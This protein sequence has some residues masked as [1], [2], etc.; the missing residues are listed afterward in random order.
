M[1]E[2][3]DSTIVLRPDANGWYSL[4]RDL[5]EALVGQLRDVVPLER[6]SITEVPLMTVRLARRLAGLPVE[7]LWLWSPVTRPAL[8]H[9]LELPGL[10]ELDVHSLHGPGR[11]AG[12]AGTRLEAARINFYM[13]EQDLLEIARCA[14]LREVGARTSDLTPR[15]LA[16]L[17]ALPELTTLGVGRTDFD[18]RMARLTS[19][20]TT[21]TSLDLGGTQI[22]GAGLEHLVRMTQL[23]TLDLWATDVREGDLPLLKHLPQLEYLSLGNY[24]GLP[25]LAAEPVT[26]T[27]LELP[28]LQRVWLDGIRLAPEQRKALEAR[29]ELAP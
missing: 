15:A 11:L 18:D 5:D 16:A 20:S 10:R 6:L 24:G 25:S 12:F 23:R 17:L 1:N 22:T 21:L 4:E 3:F 13:T 9:I 14:S 2:A 28:S 19:R 7:K 26:R 8:R 27:L 29:M